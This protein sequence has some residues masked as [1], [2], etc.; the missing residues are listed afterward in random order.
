MH[1]LPHLDIQNPEYKSVR[2]GFGEA[3]V[4]CASGHEEVVVVCADLAESIRLQA[5]A[6]QYPTRFIETGVAEQNMLG[7]AAGLA[8]SGK[9]P[10]A[11]SFAA[12]NPGRTWDQLRVS[13]AYQQANVKVVGAHA[14]LTVGPDGATHQALEDIA[15]TSVLPNLTVIVPTDYNEI[16]RI[17]PAVIRH[18]GPVY[19]RLGR[20]KAPLVTD[21]D[22]EFTIGKAYVLREG[23]DISVICTGLMV[24]EALC[25]A[26]TLAE[27]GIS[28]EVV[29][30]PTIKPLDNETV[31][32][33]VR[34]TGAAVTAEEAQ[35]H[36]G[37]GGAVCELVA[38]QYPIPVARIGTKDSFGESGQAYELL[39]TYG[40]SAQHIATSVRQTL[41]RK[42][43]P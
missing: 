18:R 28:C 34:K 25:A 38:E 24:Y 23:Q 27:E 30:V 12:F 37:L 17:V 20:E 8:L 13:V 9:I 11:A 36:G 35:I 19:I 31:L 32:E 16:Q 21:P 15:I 39:E 33:S 41:P 29:S 10:F 26:E 6:E 5:F 42:Q 14:G 1:S 40:L 3:L 43:V 7:V 4:T 22:D 2:E